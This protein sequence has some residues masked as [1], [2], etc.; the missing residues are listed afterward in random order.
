MLSLVKRNSLDMVAAMLHGKQGVARHHAE[1]AEDKLRNKGFKHEA[2]LLKN[3]L[4]T[5]KMAESLH[6]D[7][8]YSLDLGE[9]DVALKAV[10]AEK[11]QLP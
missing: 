7:R 2:L 3:K 8:I 5:F 6:K 10:L 1:D 9:L 4:T 11:V